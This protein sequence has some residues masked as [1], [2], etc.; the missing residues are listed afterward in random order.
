MH[1]VPPYSTVRD[2]LTVGKSKEG[3]TVTGLYEDF[4][5]VLRLLLAGI[6]IDE[7][8]YLAQ[9]PDIAQAVESGTIKSARQ[10]FVEHGYFEGR[11]PFHIVVD[12]Q[13]YLLQNPDVAESVRSGTVESAQR[14]FELDG[15]REGRLPCALDDSGLPRKVA[16]PVQ[17]MPSLSLVNG[18]GSHRKS[19]RPVR[20]VPSVSPGSRDTATVGRAPLRAAAR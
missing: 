5:D 4:L 12:E 6:D 11:P 10:H 3:A 2:F 14:H 9:N 17:P 13:W 8:W 7:T 15:Y 20:L 18:S 16:R 1:Y 19:E